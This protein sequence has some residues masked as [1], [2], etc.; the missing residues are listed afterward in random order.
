MG[1]I[2]IYTMRN[3]TIYTM[4]NRTIYTMRNIKEI[5]KMYPSGPS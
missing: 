4:R 1:N 2:T 3:R 5:P